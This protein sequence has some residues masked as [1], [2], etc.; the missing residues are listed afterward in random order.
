MTD[1]R[2]PVKLFE[3]RDRMTFMPVI[4]VKLM[5]GGGGDPRADAE[6]WLLRRA[7]YAEEQIDPLTQIPLHLEPYV[8]L[9]KLDGD[10]HTEYDP[11]AWGNRTWTT[12][13]DYIIKHWDTL[14]SGQV[15][16]VE[17]ILGEAGAP[18]DSERVTHGL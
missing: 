6:R 18:K 13:H 7:G 14:E 15:I 2:F 12:T 4:A 9:T 17:Y 8:L 11:Y 5:H 3:V 10:V 1:N 16:D